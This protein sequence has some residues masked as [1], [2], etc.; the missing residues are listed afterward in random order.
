MGTRPNPKDTTMINGMLFI[1]SLIIAIIGLLVF[2]TGINDIL[3]ALLNNGRRSFAV[4]L[5]GGTAV[6]ILGYLTMSIAYGMN[7]FLP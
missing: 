6:A 4:H 2:L 1:G 7:P 5:L 3:A